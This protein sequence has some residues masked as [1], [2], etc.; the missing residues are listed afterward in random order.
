L[1]AEIVRRLNIE[2]F[3]SSAGFVQ[4][5]LIDGTREKRHHLEISN[6]TEHWSLSDGALTVCSLDPAQF[7]VC[8]LPRPSI[9]KVDKTMS[10]E[11]AET[12]EPGGEP[13]WV[14]IFDKDI[15][16]VLSKWNLC[17]PIT[18]HDPMLDM[19]IIQRECVASP[20]A[21]ISDPLA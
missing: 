9:G 13:L 20:A 3:A 1:K 17:T 8:L 15:N 10:G 5:Q 11:N 4:V 18:S 12:D 16:E 21:P 2:R 7:L 6:F 19:P 14:T